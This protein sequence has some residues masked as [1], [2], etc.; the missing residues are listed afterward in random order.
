[1]Y[2]LVKTPMRAVTITTPVRPRRTSSRYTVPN[3]PLP[4]PVLAYFVHTS[5]F[6]DVTGKRAG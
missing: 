4:R 1:V 6:V 3:D 2:G 5:S